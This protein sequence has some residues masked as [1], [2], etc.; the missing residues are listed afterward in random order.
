MYSIYAGDICIYSDVFA[1]ENMK[2]IN[3]KLILEDNSA[4]S[5]SITLT[6][7]NAGYATIERLTTDISVRKDGA[8]IWAGRVLSESTDF[9]NNRIL[10]CEGE[11]AFFNDSI[12]PP[13]AY[14]SSTIRE[15]MERLIAVHNS[16]ESA[17]RRFTIGAVTVN[18][19]NLPTFYTN[20]ES[21]MD[22]LN[23]LIEKYGGHMR[24]RKENGVRYLDYLADY[25]STCAQT[26][27]FGTNL[28]DFTRKWDLTEFTTVL[29][30]LG[31]RLADSSIEALDA[32]LTVESV[33]G[34]SIYVT[35]GTEALN[36]YGRIEKTVSW[37][38]VEDAG[39]LLEKARAYLSDVQFDNMVLELSALDL[40]YLNADE[41]TV[42]LLDQIRVISYPHG[43]DR[44]FPVTR[45]EIPLDSPEKT[46]FKLGDSVRSSLTSLS[47]QHNSEILE[48][49]ENLPKA[50]TLLKTAKQN[51]Q[52]IM[53]LATNG[54]I[55]ITKDATG[56]EALIIS[57]EKD[58]T[59]SDR[60]WKW[61][62][63]GLAYFKKKSDSQ[64]VDLPIAITMDGAIVADFITAGTMSADRVRTGILKSTNNNVVFDLDNG[65]LVMKKGSI[66]LGKYSSSTK[67]YQFEVKDDGTMYAGASA[68]FAGTLN[69]AK[70]SFGGEL[71]AASGT[72]N[73]TVRAED[74]IDSNTGESML[75]N[76]KWKDE[77][78][79]SISANKITAG[80]ITA[81][82]SIESPE[83]IAGLFYNTGKTHWLELGFDDGYWGNGLGLFSTHFS[84]KEPLF[85]IYDNDFGS[86]IISACGS[87]IMYADSSGLRLLYGVW[88]FRYAT[89]YGLEARF[90]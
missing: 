44:L 76:G 8:E 6:P 88:D 53:D 52:E 16:K 7:A 66:Q 58:Y 35:S 11:L 85:R 38:E 15:Y 81:E 73:G 78:L 74:F 49:I 9:Y 86:A 29:V 31:K 1:V 67:H 87:D 10:Y 39:V 24:V 30:P 4:G 71:V 27:R 17:N 68:I 70:G 14:E 89:T 51:A 42:K 40:H 37:N 62:M 84:D 13:A 61:N 41:E 90:G 69:A 65:S 23:G 28:I 77:Y 75:N 33:N 20:Y 50:H 46:Q 45:L 21:T 63:N 55:T 47:N 32:Y 59:K 18:D 43:L 34:G 19:G 57:S 26:I 22:V 36:A 80:T 64:D 60:Y 82:I 3:P 54:Y 48:K 12:Q 79:D 56:S 5:L 25:I 83:I 2:A 72:F